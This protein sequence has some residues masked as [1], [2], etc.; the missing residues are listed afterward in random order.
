MYIKVPKAPPL[1]KETA[2]RRPSF[3]TGTAPPT[4]PAGSGNTL[5]KQQD[6]FQRRWSIGLAGGIDVFLSPRKLEE[7]RSRPKS[8]SDF[9]EAERI[10]KTLK[11]QS[12]IVLS[13]I[14]VDEDGEIL[15]IYLGWRLKVGLGFSAGLLLLS[16][17]RN[18]AKSPSSLRR[19]VSRANKDA[20]PK[21][22]VSG[23]GCVLI[24]SHS[25]RCLTLLSL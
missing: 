7:L 19:A 5:K 21:N 13:T 22:C 2:I 10:T 25:C 14:I 9:A 23:H 15:F 12:P 6:L 24:S 3:R 18:L 11:S 4:V 20:S 1:P 16:A 17:V 8:D